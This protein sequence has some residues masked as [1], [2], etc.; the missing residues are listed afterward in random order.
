[1]LIF[2]LMSFWLVVLVGWSFY[3]MLRRTRS[4]GAMQ[5][6]CPATRWRQRRGRVSAQQSWLRRYPQWD[7]QVGEAIEPA[8]ATTPAL[9]RRAGSYGATRSSQPPP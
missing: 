7:L 2:R 3:V 5:A 4:E 6:A 1:V 8:K 9:E